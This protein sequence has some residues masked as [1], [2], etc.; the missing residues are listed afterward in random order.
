[1]EAGEIKRLMLFEP[2]GHAKSV[3]LP[4]FYIGRNADKQLIA[5]SHTQD[6]AAGFGRKVRNLFGADEWPFEAQLAGDSPAADQWSTS[7]GGGYYAVGVGGAVHGRRAD[8]IIIDDPTKSRADADSK[9]KREALWQW[10]KTDLRTR[11]EAL[12]LHHPDPDALAHRRS[13]RPD[14]QV[15]LIL[16]YAWRGQLETPDLVVKLEEMAR[17]YKPTR[18]LI[19][20]KAAG[21]PA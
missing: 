16:R 18:I 4:G 17:K 12:R 15:N 1:V 7:K 9:V 6:L 2:P 3:L 8:G 11:T 14:P 5:G 13:G 21:L 20:N 19:E 10:Y